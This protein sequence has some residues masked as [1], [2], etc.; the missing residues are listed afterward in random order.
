[1]PHFIKFLYHSI[2]HVTLLVIAPFVVLRCLWNKRLREDLLSQLCSG[3]DLLTDIGS[4]W[5]HASSLGEVRA[6]ANLRN[7]LKQA[8]H[9]VVLSTSTATGYHLAKKENM[10]PVFRLPP[11]SPYWIRPMV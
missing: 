2:V 8:G 7:A 4:I 6:A 10:G 1:M 9:R 3:K 11:D 5:I